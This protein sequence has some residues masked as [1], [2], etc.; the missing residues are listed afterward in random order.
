M[1]SLYNIN[2][3]YGKGEDVVHAL[4]DVSLEISEG[5]MIAI[6]GKSGSGKSTLLNILGC[7]DQFDSGEYLYREMEVQK[8]TNH[9]LHMFRKKHVGFVFQHFALMNQHTVYENVEL[10]LLIQN[11]SKKQRKKQVYEALTWMGIQN[12]ARKMPSKLSGGEQQRCAIAR[13]LAS[14]NELILADEPT[15]ALDISTG[16]EIMSIFKELNKHGKTIVIVTHDLRIAECAQRI[17]Y[18]KDGKIGEYMD[19]FEKM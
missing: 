7:M 16:S 15:G 4:C 14:G 18:M 5:E 11:V 10:P 6:M 1:I 13:A 17:L 8:M 2:K 12:L 3:L 9:E 19:E